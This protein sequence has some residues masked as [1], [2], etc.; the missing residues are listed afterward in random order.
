MKLRAI[1]ANLSNYFEMQ[2]YHNNKLLS[3]SNI[4]LMFK[5]NTLKIYMHNVYLIFLYRLFPRYNC[6]NRLCTFE[7]FNKNSVVFF[8]I[9]F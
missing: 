7:V 1:I 8:L 4:L 2:I 5:T 3:L 6:V 9:H